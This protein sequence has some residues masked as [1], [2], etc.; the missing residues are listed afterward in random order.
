MKIARQN[1]KRKLFFHSVYRF[2]LLFPYQNY[3]AK[4]FPV[5]QMYARL[6]KKTSIKRSV[7]VFLKRF[8]VLHVWYSS[9]NRGKVTWNDAVKEIQACSLKTFYISIYCDFFISTSDPPS[10][11]EPSFPASFLVPSSGLS[12]YLEKKGIIVQTKNNNT[13]QK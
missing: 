2:Y 12:S 13:I 7:V 1:Y 4:V 5:F 10:D 8:A 3:S 11:E 9:Q 6:K